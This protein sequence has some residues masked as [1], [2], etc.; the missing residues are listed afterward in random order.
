M[1][2]EENTPLMSQVRID[3]VRM[4]YDAAPL[5]LFAMFIN[6][7]ILSLVLLPV[8]DDHILVMWVLA[9]A[10]VGVLRIL[11]SVGFG[12]V[13]PSTDRIGPWVI[14]ARLGTILS[15]IVWGAA[16]YFM[17]V[18]ESLAY[19]VVLTVF[20]AGMSAGAVTTLSAQRG[21]A[22][23]YAIIAV[24]PLFYRFTQTDH[25]FTWVMSMVIP[26]FILMLIATTLH[27][28]R[29][30]EEMFVERYQRRQAQQR[31]RT[32]NQVLEMLATGAPLGKILEAIVLGIERENPHM[33]GSILL[34][35][36]SGTRLYCGAA[37]SLP[38]F[39]VSATSG[40]LIGQGVGSCGTAAFTGERVIVEDIQTHP[41]WSRCRDV[42]RKARLGACWSEPIISSTGDVLGTFAIYHR[43]P[44]FP[45]EQ[46]I[47]I[48]EQAAN[49]AGIAIEGRGNEEALQL[50]SMVYQ[51]SSEAMM[52]TDDQERIVAINP[53]FTEVTG[54]TLDDVNGRDPRL[55]SSGRQ[56][57]EFYHEMWQ[58]L[59]ATGHW[60]GE[61]W[62]RRKNG[63][64]FAEWLTINT[65][66]DENG[67]VH[68]RVSLFSDIT[69]KKKADALIWTQA[70][71][72]TLTNLPN[73]RLF[74]DRLEQGIKLAM[75][76]GHSLAL[77]FIDLDRFKEVN[78][79]FG[80]HMGDEL[81]KEA[82]RRII[83]CV[84]DSDTVARLGGDEFVAILTELGDLS[85]IDMVANKIIDS[86]GEPYQVGEDLSYVTASIG[87]TVYPDDAETA[88][89]LL[90]NADQAMFSA[91]EN[92]RNR[93]SYFTRHLQEE[94]QSR[95]RMV[96]DM[97]RALA[98]GEFS[99][100]YQPVVDVITGC[101]VKAEALLRWE[102]PQQGYISPASFIPIAEE[103]GAIHEIG[104]LVFKEAVQRLK[105]WRQDYD[106]AFQVSINK[107]PV[108]FMKESYEHED[109]VGYLDQLGLNGDGLVIEITEGVVM[110]LTSSINDKLLHL[111]EAGVQVAIDDFGTGYS[112]LAYL[113]KFDIDYLKLDR[114][115]VSNLESDTSDMVLS[116]AIVVMAHKLGFKV[117][118]EGV[119]TRAQHRILT[120]I[121]CDYAQGF[122]F[123]KA[124]PA[125][126]F[127]LL[128]RKNHRVCRI[129]I[130][131]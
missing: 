4:I 129:G 20:I 39:Y 118:A 29:V 53:A 38:E 42:A 88:E 81:L 62:N 32:R 97:H 24:V 115:F 110:K 47:S 74:G 127:E 116:E 101:I 71:F 5:A 96:N 61:I 52:V 60:Q 10:M 106:P 34:L 49:L 80:H 2:A 73:R 8:V 28:S 89:D 91:K 79:T 54:Y 75:R 36:D 33:L 99:V 94:A 3:Q 67:K 109:W 125:E 37:P 117:I 78:D 85:G 92:G 18:Q 19:Q 13:Q 58:A 130:A 108:Q 128:L 44:T 46:E 51:N 126:E 41:F 76:E 17:F 131:G 69:V 120:E 65:I 112:S 82:A 35:G 66:F 123:S 119:E 111:R 63:E 22:I 107:S 90:R 9:L 15:G 122:L 59:G 87:I 6:G 40:F 11:L 56:S 64:E 83:S 93:Y 102:H 30:I 12:M 43:E 23:T 103:T 77:L 72:D 86:L 121:G 84:R 7:A 55:L 16:S 50:A 68:R 124:V 45:S 105:Q 98:V 100:Y 26:M 1:R 31:D 70:N 95:M 114:S 25:D 113:K 21:P 57:G 48:I 14:G 27:H 104:N